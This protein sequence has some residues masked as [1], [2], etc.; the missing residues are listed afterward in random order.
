MRLNLPKILA[1]RMFGVSR[2]GSLADKQHMRTSMEIALVSVLC[3]NHTNCF[4]SCGDLERD[5]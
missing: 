4:S 3:K 2:V 5:E 1:A